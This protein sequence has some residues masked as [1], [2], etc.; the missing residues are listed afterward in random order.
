[1]ENIESAL[2]GIRAKL[3]QFHWKDIYNMDETG[4]FFRLEA[5]H[6]LATK[7]LEGRKKD[8]E[9]IT[10]AVCCNGD[11]SDKV[12]LWIIGKYAN[13][14]CFKHVNMSNLSCHY[15]A[16][17]RAWMTGLLFQEFVCWFDKRMNGRK[18]LLIVDNCPAH[19]KVIEGLINVELFF[20][21]PNTTSMIQPYDAGIIRA[22]K[23]HYRR[24]F[25]SSILED[26]EVGETN[27]EKINILNAMTLINAA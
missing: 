25:Y 5:D 3:D 26:Y 2:P 21:P 16:N 13:P 23:I 19:P 24:R 4:L 9:R 11:S 15:R 8:E 14:R 12:P 6:S 17:K 10:V 7:Q 27:P 1:M 22:L 20:L 18:V